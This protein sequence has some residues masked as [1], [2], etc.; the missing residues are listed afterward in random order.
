MSLLSHVPNGVAKFWRSCPSCG[1]KIEMGTKVGI[2]TSSWPREKIPVCRT[3]HADGKRTPSSQCN[4]LGISVA[5]GRKRK[6][7]P[8]KTWRSTLCDF[9][10]ARGVSKREAE[11]LAAATVYTGETCCPLSWEGIGGTKVLRM[12]P[13]HFPTFFARRYDNY[14]C[15]VCHI[16]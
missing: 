6:G 1:C 2:F 14:F 3:P 16:L 13:T 5:D 8:R 11:E 15:H 4:R 7:Q 10:H 12:H 9:L